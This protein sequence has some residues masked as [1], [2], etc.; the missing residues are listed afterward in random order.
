MREYGARQCSRVKAK[1]RFS[2]IDWGGMA[3]SISGSSAWRRDSKAPNAEP[4]GMAAAAAAVEE[5][6]GEDGAG[7]DAHGSDLGA[8]RYDPEAMNRVVDLD[9]LDEDDN[10]EISDYFTEGDRMMHRNRIL[11]CAMAVV[12]VVGVA[13]GAMI[14]ANPSMIPFVPTTSLPGKG[15]GANLQVSYPAPQAAKQLQTAR[16]VV[17]ACGTTDNMSECQ[18]L[19]R[20]RICCVEKDEDTYNCRNDEAMNCGVF[21]ACEALVEDVEVPDVVV[22]AKTVAKVERHARWG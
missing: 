19:C 18:R 7:A 9:D 11:T 3:G 2:R 4:T 16:E 1:K 22:T 12:A 17:A 15:T 20:G 6:Y 21:V 5:L 13:M 8:S 10:S 14:A